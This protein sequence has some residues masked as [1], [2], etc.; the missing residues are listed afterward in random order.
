MKRGFESSSERKNVADSFK[1]EAR[2][3]KRSE[4]NAVKKE[5]RDEYDI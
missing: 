4:K 2:S 3:L 5:I 1:R